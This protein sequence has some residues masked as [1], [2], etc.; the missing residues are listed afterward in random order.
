M[1][2]FGILHYRLPNPQLRG[3]A[4]LLLEGILA[5]MEEPILQAGRLMELNIRALAD[6]PEGTPIYYVSNH[7]ANSWHLLDIQVHPDCPGSDESGRY[8]LCQRRQTHFGTVFSR[9]P[10]TDYRD[11]ADTV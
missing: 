8:S 6:I 4:W 2:Q 9:S 5:Q 7:G 11:G 3:W 1:R 10:K